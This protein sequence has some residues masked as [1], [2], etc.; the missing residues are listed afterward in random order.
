MADMSVN[1]LARSV[2]KV[3]TPEGDEIFDAKEIYTFVQN[4]D[5]KS[6]KAIDTVL[7]KIN[8]LDI[9]KRVEMACEK[10]SCK[11]VWT[12]EVE[13]NAADFFVVGS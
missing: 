9:D 5:S 13:F 11:N 8:S 2:I 10:E 3:A 6:A 12:T 4:I 1:L 7:S